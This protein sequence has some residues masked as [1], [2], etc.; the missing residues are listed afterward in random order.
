[1]EL[2]ARVKVKGGGREKEGGAAA[3]REKERRPTWAARGREA[4]PVFARLRR[5][6]EPF[7]PFRRRLTRGGDT[8]RPGQAFNR[9]KTGF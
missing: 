8:R 6:S 1:M 9:E 3:R 2:K 7:L 4:S 5:F